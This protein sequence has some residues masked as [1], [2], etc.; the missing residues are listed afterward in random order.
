[1][2]REREKKNKRQEKDQGREGEREEKDGCLWWCG[3]H[4]I[5]PV[6]ASYIPSLSNL[7]SSEAQIRIISQQCYEVRLMCYP[8]LQ[9]RKLRLRKV[10]ELAHTATVRI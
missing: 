7:T 10:Q 5:P 4:G 8:I 2:R 1:M 3:N 6:R 9:K